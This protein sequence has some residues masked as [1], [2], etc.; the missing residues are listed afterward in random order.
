[1]TREWKDVDWKS[2]ADKLKEY[3]SQ[4]EHGRSINIR[5]EEI[6]KYIGKSDALLGEVFWFSF[7]NLFEEGIVTKASSTATGEIVMQ[8]R[9]K[10]PGDTWQM[11]YEFAFRIFKEHRISPQDIS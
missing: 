8:F 6:A 9:L 7:V 1:M 11:L 3:I 4:L 10:L 2:L 5:T